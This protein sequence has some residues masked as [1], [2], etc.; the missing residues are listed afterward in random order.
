[1]PVCR[2]RSVSL[3]YRLEGHA[4]RPVLVLSNSLGTDFG[5]WD[6]Q[7]PDL[8]KHFRLLRYDGR[9]HGASSVAKAG[10]GV[11]DMAQDVVDLADHL[12][13]EQF[14]FC[15]LSLGAVVGLHLG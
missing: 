11:G 15:G 1:M 2:P 12:G 4:D 6:P 10:F 14:A 7:V 3:A 8:T 13:I 9:G 5:M